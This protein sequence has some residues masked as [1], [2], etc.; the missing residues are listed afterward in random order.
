MKFKKL[1]VLCVLLG[2]L[3]IL[4]VVKNAVRKKNEAPTP[5]KSESLFALT[6]ELPEGFISKIV[7]Y[8][9][10]DEKNKLTLA[11]DTLN[12]W[13]LEEKFGLKA[14]KEMVEALLKD[15][16]GLE[17]EVRGDSRSVWN[18]FGITDQQGVHVIFESHG[19]NP[20]AHLVVSFT[21]PAW[22]SNFVR[23]FDSEKVVLVDKDIL[24]RLN[25]YAQDAKLDA[26][27]FADYKMLSLEAKDVTRFEIAR[28]SESPV[29]FVK[30]EGE[31]NA[32]AT[33]RLEADGRKE[34]DTAQV[35]TYLQ[36]AANT[37]GQECFDRKASVYGLDKPSLK[38]SFFIKGAA[39]PLELV[40]G[41]YLEAQKAFYAKATPGGLVYRVPEAS[42]TNLKKDKSFFFKISPNAS[43]KR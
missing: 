6:K 35:D 36:F 23:L 29:V 39:P 10:D 21:K 33:W 28:G 14:R 26:N 31:N 38:L 13:I 34:I 17:G 15:A 8:K 12:N 32:A 18:D 25:L 24:S 30:K 4:A 37:Y 5:L 7:V 27:T 11:K 2:V 16:A 40:V 41:T 42:V 22:N 3:L 43:K 19:P 9:G 1:L 20:L